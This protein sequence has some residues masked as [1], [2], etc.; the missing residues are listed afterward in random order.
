[1]QKIALRGH[2][3]E[4]LLGKVDIQFFRVQ[5]VVGALEAADSVSFVVD[6]NFQTPFLLSVNE[7]PSMIQRESKPT[8]FSD[9][10]WF[11]SVVLA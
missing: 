9:E 6:R 10:H 3:V 7:F 5:P 2:E 11:Y 8:I 1:L 4:G